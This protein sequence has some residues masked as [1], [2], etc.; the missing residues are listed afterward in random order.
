MIG[1]ELV[2]DLAT[3]APDPHAMQFLADFGLKHELIIISCGPDGNI[4]RFIP[5]LITSLVELDSAIDTIEVGL[6]AYESRK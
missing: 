1:V 2:Q 3:R 4:I 6:E 5:P